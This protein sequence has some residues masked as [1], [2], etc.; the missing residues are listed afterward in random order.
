M[1]KLFERPLDDAAFVE[2]PL[3]QLEGYFGGGLPKGSRL[4]SKAGWT[5][6]TGDVDA[7]YRRHDAAY[8]ELPSGRALIL[9]AFTRGKAMSESQTVLP[10]IA[11]KA[12]ELVS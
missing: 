11:E 3:A 7:S 1:A 9:V 10:A 5:G 8:V 12:A 2:H 4:W 6:W